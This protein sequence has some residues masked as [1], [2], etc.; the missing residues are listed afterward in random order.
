MWVWS[1][2]KDNRSLSSMESNLVI[3]DACLQTPTN[4]MENLKKKI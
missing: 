1:E 2:F 4:E 3:S